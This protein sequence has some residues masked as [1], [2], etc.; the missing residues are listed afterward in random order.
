[1][2]G[3]DPND[4][5]RLP[6]DPQFPADPQQ[7][8]AAT[9][10]QQPDASESASATAPGGESSADDSAAMAESDS[11]SSRPRFLIGSQR[12]P[13]AYRARRQRDWT[14]VEEPAKE[15]EGGAE[16]ASDQAAQTTRHREPRRGRG[17]RPHGR[18]D[19]G[20]SESE[21]RQSANVPSPACRVGTTG[22]GQGEG[23]TAGIQG[24]S[25]PAESAAVPTAVDL[26]A[27]PAAPPQSPP[28]PVAAAVD[29]LK[30][31]VPEL[32]DSIQP[33]VRA[34]APVPAEMEEDFEKAFDQALDGASLDDLLG[35]SD[36]ISKQTVLEPES[37]HQGRIVAIRKDE[38]FVALGG[39][40]QGVVSARQFPEPPQV[41]TLLEVIV[42]RL[43]AEDG[44]YD[45][46]L[47]N[48][49]M[50]VSNWDD[51]HQGMLVETQVTGH[52]T[53]G[54]ECEV[55][56]IRGFIPV[57]QIALYR[58]ED[59]AQFV[60]QRFTCLITEANPA[61]QNLVLSR[62]AVLEREKEEARQ[63][64]LAALQPGQIHQGVVRK[65]MNFGAF[66]DL[67][68]VDGLLHVSQLAWGR[69]EHPKDV[70]AEGQSIQ[71]RIE[72]IDHETGKISLA[73]RDLQESPWSTA[74]ATYPPNSIVRGKVSK[75]ME[76]GAFVEV[77][78]GV[79]GL[80]HISELSHKRVWRA[81]DVVHEGDEVEV[82]VLSVN[83]EAQRMS[84]SIRA[85]SKPE[86]TKK[87]VEEAR[88]A[89]LPPVAPSKRKGPDRPLRGGLGKSAGGD[90]FG[91]NW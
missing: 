46:A 53:G 21:Q 32:L 13:A 17:G 45:L 85:L 28:P 33:V 73:Y 74:A 68:G 90:R 48:T 79:E 39:R 76:F 69:V 82:L 20:R 29:D 35:V 12:D 31:D 60:G 25:R 19:H 26:P 71:V 7:P 61:R 57:S 10:L 81:S 67:G 23:P 83:P 2:T 42:Q 34:P 51:V 38:V 64:L 59:L 27:A 9:T 70:L 72:R 4:Q 15:K 36:A 37:H 84:L 77:Q 24:E 3:S 86:P 89:E 43:N 8:S 75:L 88:E 41:G 16:G 63:T 44:L 14:P 66:V 55:N 49:A 54:L 58:V 1:M 65:L 18:S 6:T 40:E 5:Q 78:P 91:L 11:Q 56:H 47:P 50:E 22:R 30:A 87:E 62:R 80:V 52:N